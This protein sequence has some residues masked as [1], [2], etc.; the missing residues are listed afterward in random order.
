MLATGLILLFTLVALALVVVV[1]RLRHCAGSG[2]A[3]AA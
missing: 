2:S 3:Q 1:F